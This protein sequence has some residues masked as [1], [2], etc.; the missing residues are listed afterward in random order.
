MSYQPHEKDMA[1]IHDDIIV[2]FNGKREKWSSTMVVTGIPG[3]YS[4]MAR[5][6]SLPV[7][8]ATRLILEGRI[9]IRGSVLPIYPEIYNPI[10]EELDEFGIKFSHQKRVID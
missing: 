8:I 2:D 10:L 5:S 4:A 7:A 3:G 9:T 1:M 6:V